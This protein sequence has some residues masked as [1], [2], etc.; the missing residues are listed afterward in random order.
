CLVRQANAGSALVYDAPLNSIMTI[1]AYLFAAASLAGS[2]FL[3]LAAIAVRRFVRQ[4]AGDER[5]DAPITVLKPLHGEDA[6]LRANLRSVCEQDHPS[7]QIVFGVRDAADPAVAVVQRLMSDLPGRDLAVV[8]EPLVRG[9]NFK[10]SNLENM[11]P[12]AKHG[13]L[14][15]ADSDM[16]V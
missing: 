3:L 2:L 1:V 4:R 14:V 10:V 9:S 6:E 13:V 5:S 11:L 15:V 12:A 7:Y 8:V 16:R